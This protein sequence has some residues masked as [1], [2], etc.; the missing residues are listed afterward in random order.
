MAS[1]KIKNFLLAQASGNSGSME[2]LIDRRQQ[3][4]TLQQV[5]DRVDALGKQMDEVVAFLADFKTQ[6]NAFGN[7]DATPPADIT[8]TISAEYV[9]ADAK[10]FTAIK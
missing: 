5:A 9:D 7:V 3:V 6:W 2:A 10:P 1:D 4:N 8:A